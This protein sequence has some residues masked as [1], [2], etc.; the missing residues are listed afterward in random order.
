MVS[1]MAKKISGKFPLGISKSDDGAYNIVVE[2]PRLT[3]IIVGRA[4]K[5]LSS[6]TDVEYEI[7]F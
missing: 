6:V 4:M 7:E 5:E 1:V 2:E 3:R